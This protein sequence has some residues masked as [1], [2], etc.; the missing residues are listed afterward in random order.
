MMTT[1]P[2]TS[3]TRTCIS[4]VSSSGWCNRA[5]L[6]PGV[7]RIE[8]ISGSLGKW[9][10]VS[11]FFGI[12]VLAYSYSLDSVSRQSS[13]SGQ[14]DPK[15]MRYTLQG[16]ATASFGQHS[17][18]TTLGVLSGVIGAAAQVSKVHRRVE[19]S[20]HSSPSPPRSP[21]LS[22]VS[23]CSASLCSSTLSAL[24]SRRPVTACRL[25]LA[26]SFSTS[27]ATP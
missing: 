2:L 16:Y 8:A 26:E 21:T 24:S 13:P 25:T 12:F 6:T 22:A 3:P 27:W 11:A 17:L 4:L 7:K 14:A 19:T 10:K 18:L 15:S 20:A 1:I 23:S 9:G 5:R